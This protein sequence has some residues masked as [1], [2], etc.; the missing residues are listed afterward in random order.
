MTVPTPPQ[1]LSHRRLQLQQR[2]RE[3]REQLVRDAEVLQPW[4]GAADRVRSATHWLQ[5]HPLWV[6]GL[7]AALVVARPRRA[8][9]LGLKL[10]SG[11][12]MWQRVRAALDGPLRRR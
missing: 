4:L 8:V 11:W 1:P 5:Q 6:A 10:W 2:S 12:Q 9:A 3:L 7:V